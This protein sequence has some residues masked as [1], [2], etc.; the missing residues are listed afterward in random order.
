MDDSTKHKIAHTIYLIATTLRAFT[1]KEIKLMWKPTLLGVAI[2][3]IFATIA[4]WSDVLFGS[5]QKEFWGC[6]GIV[7]LFSPCTLVYY[8]RLKQWVLKW[9]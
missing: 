5:N 7:G 3:I 6:L 2:A 8:R 9:K 1:L 4:E